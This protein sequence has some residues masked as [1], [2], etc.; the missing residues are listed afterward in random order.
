MRNSGSEK[1]EWEQRSYHANGGS[2]RRSWFNRW[3]FAGKR[4]YEV[5]EMIKNGRPRKEVECKRKRGR[6]RT[7]GK[8]KGKDE[9]VI[10]S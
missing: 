2:P 1:L 4:L 10:L 3:R 9:D 8:S 7:E 6:L 5:E